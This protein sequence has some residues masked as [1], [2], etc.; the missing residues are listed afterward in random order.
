MSLRQI[1]EHKWLVETT[2]KRQSEIYQE[3]SALENVKVEV[4]KH[5]KLNSIYG[6]VVLPHEQNSTDK[7]LLLDSLKKRYSNV[8]GLEIYQIPQ[9]GNPNNTLKIAKI[10]FEGQN[11]PADIRIMGQRREVR[12]HVPKPLQCKKCCKF[13]HSVNNCRND[14]VCAFCGSLEHP[15]RWNCGES[16]C[17]NC[18]QQHHARSKECVFYIYNTE[19]KLLMDRTGMKIK[20]A[21][22]ELQVRGIKDPTRNP[23]Y[24]T[25]VT[26]SIPKR[27]ENQINKDGDEEAVGLQTKIDKNDSL[28]VDITPEQEKDMDTE[29]NKGVNPSRPGTPDIFGYNRKYSKIFS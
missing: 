12:P 15:T 20:E 23:L 28:K 16:K 26:K 2:N 13:G 1:D 8:E 19:L 7:E 5:D 17:I 22:L 18:G 21:K 11:L 14:P 9:R 25:V 29:S 27:T 4:E 10:K 6:T 24:R 3:I